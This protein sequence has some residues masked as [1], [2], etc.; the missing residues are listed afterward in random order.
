MLDLHHCISS[1]Y[2]DLI[3]TLEDLSIAA[4]KDPDGAATL[5]SRSLAQ[6]DIDT[7]LALLRAEERNKTRS[8]QARC[9]GG[10]SGSCDSANGG[11]R[12]SNGHGV[13]NG[14]A[15]T[16][17]CPQELLAT[18]CLELLL[19]ERVVRRLCEFGVAD[20]PKGALALV[21]GAC[22][23]LLE[24]ASCHPQ[25]FQ[26]LFAPPGASLGPILGH[27][28]PRWVSRQAHVNFT[29]HT[30]PV[31]VPTFHCSTKTLDYFQR[32]CLT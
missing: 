17:G 29:A 21:M 20:R 4:E 10:K 30:V 5:L 1:R 22:A 15:S 6:D 13:G 12:S 28:L 9:G 14:T 32:I 7:M 8:E 3:G 2:R 25:R 11:D 31:I 26:K 27:V 24:Q 23:A 19:E 16:E 18:P